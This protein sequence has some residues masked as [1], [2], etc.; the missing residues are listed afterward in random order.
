VSFAATILCIASQQVFV[1]VVAYFVIYSVPKLSDIP[2]Y[3]VEG[4]G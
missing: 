4:I 2:S 3:T 1:V